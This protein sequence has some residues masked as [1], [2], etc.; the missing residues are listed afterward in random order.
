MRFHAPD[1]LSPFGKG[2]INAYMYCAGDPV[3]HSD[4]SGAIIL[5]TVQT[6]AVGAL[7]TS[8]LALGFTSPGLRGA[9]NVNT[10]RASTLGSIIGLGGIGL[11]YSAYAAV[12]P[13]V[14]TVGTVLVAGALTLQAGKVI[15]QN[16]PLLGKIVA[17]NT[18]KIF[19]GGS[20]EAKGVMVESRVISASNE[21]LN[22]IDNSSVT[23]CS[24]VMKSSQHGHV[25]INMEHFS[26]VKSSTGIRRKS[27]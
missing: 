27:I 23:R 3:N 11:S 24:S 7:Y 15:V 1:T 10:T 13:A 5:P 12:A 2:G 17:S 14:G 22:G 20:G 21:Q 8:G 16:L 4:P 18:K 25:S 26:A 9:F 6:V 19:L